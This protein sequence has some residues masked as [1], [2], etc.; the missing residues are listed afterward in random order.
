VESYTQT[1]PVA[2]QYSIDENDVATE[3]RGL[4]LEWVLLSVA[5][6]LAVGGIAVLGVSVYYKKDF[7]SVAYDYRTN[8]KLSLL[9]KNDI[10][11]N[12]YV[13]TR[14]IPTNTSSGGSTRSTTHIS[15]SGR[16]HGGGGRKF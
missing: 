14:R 15:S 2:G 7:H 12:S 11:V 3:R 13:N 6:G 9:Q 10:L 1:G 8:C 4:T 5:A 16:T